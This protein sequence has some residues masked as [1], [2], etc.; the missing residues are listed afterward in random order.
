[1][2]V[3]EKK[4]EKETKCVKAEKQKCCVEGKGGGSL[5][6]RLGRSEVREEIGDL[7]LEL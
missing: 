6:V 4:G 5:G 7:P 1:M 3:E 2:K